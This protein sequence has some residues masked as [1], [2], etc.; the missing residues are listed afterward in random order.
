MI[1]ISSLMPIK[2]R[3]T[4]PVI[5]YGSSGKPATSENSVR[6]MMV[7]AKMANPPRV[8]IFSLQGFLPSGLS[9]NLLFRATVTMLGIAS[10][11]I[12]REVIK[13]AMMLPE[14]KT[15]LT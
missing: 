5:I 1:K 12:A 3:M 10:K 15:L 14:C 6:D 2:N 4:E 7:P 8:G 9:Y 13:T 11:L